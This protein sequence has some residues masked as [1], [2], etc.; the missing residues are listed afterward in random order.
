MDACISPVTVR[1]EEFGY[2]LGKVTS[3]STQPVTIAGMTRTLG[4]DILVQQIAAQGAPFLVEI[5]LVP[6][7]STVSG[8]KWSSRQGPPQ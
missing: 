6:D 3:V 5:S 4:N 8:F 1:Q 7:T 2:M